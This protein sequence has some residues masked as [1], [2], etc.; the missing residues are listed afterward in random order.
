[1]LSV[2]QLVQTSVAQVPPT[3][4]P[5]PTQ[6]PTPT[7]TLQPGE[8]PQPTQAGPTPTD[9]PLAGIER[10]TTRAPSTLCCSAS[11]NAPP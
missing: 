4:T 6:S 7:P 2:A 5:V 11:T 9:D 10:R 3:N 8:T 1:M